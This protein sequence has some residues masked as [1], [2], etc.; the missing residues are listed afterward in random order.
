MAPEVIPAPTGHPVRPACALG[1]AV[2]SGILLGLGAGPAAAD[3]PRLAREYDLKAAFL[4]NFSRFVD[5][6]PAAVG[7]PGTPFVIGVL[8]DDPFGGSLDEVVAGDSVGTHPIH[9]QRLT[10]AAEATSC[11]ILFVSRS[12]AER[13]G[14]VLETLGSH[15]VLTVSDLDHFALRGGVIGFTV[16]GGRLKLEINLRAARA[17]GLV[18][19]SKLLRQADLVAGA[20]P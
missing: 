8:G 1:L 4:F 2:W 17:S 14:R 6:P 3:A 19:S 18:I 12:E 10:S 11:H 16:A 15:P 9:V 20:V 7:A 13:A 5:W